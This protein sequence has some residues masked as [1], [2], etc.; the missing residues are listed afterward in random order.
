MLILIWIWQ[1]LSTRL[2]PSW[3]AKSD[4]TD[5]LEYAAPPAKKPGYLLQPSQSDAIDVFDLVALLEPRRA[6]RL[7]QILRPASRDE[8]GDARSGNINPAD[9]QRGIPKNTPTT[10]VLM[11]TPIQRISVQTHLLF[12]M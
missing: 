7:R 11:D 10:I 6:V 9:R 5:T 4:H 12:T 2:S 8:S 1:T 3:G